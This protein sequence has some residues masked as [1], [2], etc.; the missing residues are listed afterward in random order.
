[1]KYK[2]LKLSLS[3]SPHAHSGCTTDVIMKDVCIAL[4]P[5]LIAAIWFFGPRALS[6]TIVSVIACVAFEWGY[7]RLMHKD[8]TVGDWSAVVTGILVAFICPVNLPY[9]T[10]ILGDF[11][12]IVVV[13]QLFGGIGMN[14]VNPALAARAF[15]FSWPSLMSG[16][17]TKPGVSI[18]VTG[19]VD[20]VTAAT[21]ME[22]LA[23]GQL[24]QASLMDLLI[25]KVGGSFGEVSAI[26]LLLG[27]VYLLATEVISLRIPL[28]YVGTV[29]VLALIFPQG[30]NAG[31]EWALYQVLSGGLLLGAIFMATDYT[32]SPVTRGGQIAFGIGCGV[33]TILLRYFGSYVEGVSFA[34]LIMNCCVGF[35]DKIGL[36]KRFGLKKGGGKK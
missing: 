22:A 32:T 36:P 4:M 34:I 30:G 10:L 8:S 25:G 18:P 17:W 31:W 23:V 27:L 11:F 26:A 2:D 5:A 20:A 16:N 15:L 3:S 21:P 28:S 19:A 33:L 7:R 6:A 29:A 13:K 1:M 12:A 9:W 35:F 14:I 24:P